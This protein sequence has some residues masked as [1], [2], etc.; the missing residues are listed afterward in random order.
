MEFFVKLKTAIIEVSTLFVTFFLFVI[1]LIANHNLLT[2]D[3]GINVGVRK[4][5]EKMTAMP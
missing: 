1:D 2:L 5:K 3:S 4:K